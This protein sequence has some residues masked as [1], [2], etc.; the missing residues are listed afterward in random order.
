M[1]NSPRRISV[2]HYLAYA[3]L[4]AGLLGCDQFGGGAD[5]G[6]NSYSRRAKG[7][8]EAKDYRSAAEAYEKALQ[9]N[10]ELAQAQLELGLLY[11]DKL[12]D[13][14]SAIY[15]YRRYLAL[16]PDS[17][18]RQLV[19]DF[20]ERAKLTFAAKLPQSPIVDPG[21]MTRLQNEKAALMQ[22]NAQLKGRVAELEK[23]LTGRVSRP[24]TVTPTPVTPTPARPVA[25]TPPPAANGRTHTVNQGD[26]LY[27]LSL[28]YYGTRASWEKIYQANRSTVPKDYKLKIGQQLVIP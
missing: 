20:I 13:P 27:S 9:V 3:V 23:T 18:K 6:G 11:D 1:S 10:P 7:L 24:V 2:V 5:P 28:H 22:E 4:A 12:N 16:K 15:H 25:A 14:V 17:D 21:E 8:A 19:Q 26:T